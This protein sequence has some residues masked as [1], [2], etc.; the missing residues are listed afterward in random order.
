MIFNKKKSLS[1]YSLKQLSRE[2]DPDEIFLDSKNLPDFDKD[3][4]E[5]RLEKPI[6][7]RAIF[8][9]AIVFILIEIVFFTKVVNLQV[10]RGNELLEKSEN[11]RLEHTPIFAMRGTIYDRNG[12]KLAWNS[13]DE[14]IIA[15]SQTS[16]ASVGTLPL[17]DNATTTGDLSLIHRSYISLP[18]F[19]HALGYVSYPKRDSNGFFYQESFIGKDGV[20]EKY[21]DLLSGKNGL[22]ISEIDALGNIREGSIIEKAQ[23][24]EGITL[25]IDSKVQAELH[26]FIK[27]LAVDKGYIGGSGAIMDI[28][29]GELLALTSYPEYESG[30]LSE[31]KNNKI[32][33]S[34]QTDKRSVFLDRAVSGVYAPGS[35]VKP[36]MAIGAL[37]EGVITPEKQILSTG[38]ITIPNPYYPELKSVFNDWKAHGWVNMRRALAVSS[39]V[40]FYEIGGGFEGQN[41]IGI[42]NIEKYARMFGLGSPTGID[43]TDEKSGTIPNPEWKAKVFNGEPWRLGDTYH[44]V[45]GQYG[46]QVTPLQMIRATATIANN[47]TLVTPHLLKDPVEDF[48]TTKISIP[49]S[50]FQVVR[51]GMRQGVL[52]GTDVGLN[53]AYV[54]VAAKTGT[55]EVG[56]AKKYINSWVVGFFPYE[57][58]RYAFAVVMEK[59]PYHNTIGG[60][61]VMR[62]MLDWM[63]TNTPEYLKEL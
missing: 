9:V 46:F 11:N 14:K 49:S 59:G 29:T 37:E 51:E 5:G 44:T 58:P 7:I 45:I 3:Q 60:V 34:Y 1:A 19:G 20:E 6:G 55:A 28:K 62:E 24:G 4:F 50:S 2:I 35:V 42:A 27:N 63:H 33:Q 57:K 18:G 31:G 13:F 43:L 8:G 12:E 26:T 36:I 54:D 38:S 56:S 32:I 40:Y 30:V 41:G 25:A 39:D 23:N 61:F 53:V 15:D 10:V 52:E 47:G 16:G 21:N 48:P 17:T 22:Q